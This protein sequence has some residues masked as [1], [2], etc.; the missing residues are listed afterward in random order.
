MTSRFVSAVRAAAE[1]SLVEVAEE[2]ETARTDQSAG[3]PGIAGNASVNSGTNG[4]VAGNASV[5]AC[6]GAGGDT[7]LL[8][9]DA[10]ND[11]PWVGERM[12]SCAGACLIS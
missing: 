12:L 8:V 11:D 9:I 7:F 5:C 6:T 3:T 1:G 10:S 4:L 2:R